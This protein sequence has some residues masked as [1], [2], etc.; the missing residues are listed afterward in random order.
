MSTKL[1]SIDIGVEEL[2][3]LV[4]SYF[5][6]MKAMQKGLGTPVKVKQFWIDVIVPD[7]PPPEYERRGYVVVELS[8]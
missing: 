8:R 7:G 6:G 5:S 2:A 1:L 3:T 4:G